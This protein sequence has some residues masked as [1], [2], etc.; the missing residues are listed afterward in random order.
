MER[1]ELPEEEIKK[2]VEFS[3]SSVENLRRQG[4]GRIKTL[5]TIK[6][7]ALEKE[8][9]RLAKK[10]GEDHPRVKKISARI[11]YNQGFFRDLNVE[12]E[13]ADVDVPAFD[14]DSWT[15]HGRVLDKKRKGVHGLT[16]GL[17]DEK[18]NWIRRMGYGCTDKRGYFSITY[19]SEGEPRKEISGEMKVFLYVSDKSHKILYKDREALYFKIGE[20]N[21]REVY[22]P[23]EEICT[24]PIPDA[25]WKREVPTKIKAAEIVRLEKI[26]GIGTKRAEKLRKARIADIEAFS[27]ADEAKLKEILGNVDVRGMKRESASLLK[28]VREASREKE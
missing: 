8:R 23:E 28:R 13:R 1:R 10:L 24:P 6:N 18:G 7:E 15:V 20:V 19:R 27:K 9:M 4:L 16:V 14:R 21:Y 11:K 3:I 25:K 22:L 26:K 2:K 17:F 12:S 5:H